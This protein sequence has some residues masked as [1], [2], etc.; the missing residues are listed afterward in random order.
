MEI[1]D[2]TLKEIIETSDD[3]TIQYCLKVIRAAYITNRMPLLIQHLS[4]FAEQEQRYLEL[5]EK[6]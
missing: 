2:K 3:P 6:K 4:V 1:M 5:C